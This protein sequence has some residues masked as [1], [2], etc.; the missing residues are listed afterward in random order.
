M[1]TL[2]LKAAASSTRMSI[3]PA[4]SGAPAGARRRAS[5]RYTADHAYHNRVRWSHP[6]NAPRHVGRPHGTPRELQLFLGAQE[7][8]A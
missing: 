3:A 1:S 7:D 4:P 6:M 2:A 8:G 5:T